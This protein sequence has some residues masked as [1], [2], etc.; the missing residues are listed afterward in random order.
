MAELQ[1]AAA[2]AILADPAVENLS[3]FIGVDAA[4]NTM[5]HTG[6]MLINL[7]AAIAARQAEVMA[8]PARAVRGGRRA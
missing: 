1:Q 2:R 6:G 3:S 7:Q 4:N 8:A 5:L